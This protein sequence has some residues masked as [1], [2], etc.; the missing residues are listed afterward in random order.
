MSKDIFPFVVRGPTDRLARIEADN[1]SHALDKVLATNPD[2]FVT[3]Q[4]A[5]RTTGAIA[6]RPVVLPIVKTQNK[7]FI[8][9]TQTMDLQTARKQ[10]ATESKAQK[11]KLYI[12][13]DGEG[14]CILSSV[15][16][17]NPDNVMAAFVNGN[18]VALDD[19]KQEQAKTTKVN[20]ALM[21]SS[22]K[23]LSKNQSNKH[24][25]DTRPTM[26]T[27]KVKKVAAK[28]APKKAV[29][30]TNG[31]KPVLA[32]VTGEKKNLAVTKIIALIKAG[33]RV[34]RQSNPNNNGILQ[35]PRLQKMANKDKEIAVIVVKA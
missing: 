12:N 32:T 17:K 11:K 3:T 4:F 19:M 33:T 34:Y 7:R 8:L 18:E 2:K 28:A 27:K 16:D 9:I 1:Y 31:E 29:K 5:Q 14:E 25:D 13:V 20:A 26:A 10:A 30:K 15:A 21:K 23:A 22:K 24:G 6:K 35:L